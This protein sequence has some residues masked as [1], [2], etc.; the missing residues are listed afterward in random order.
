MR[1]FWRRDNGSGSG[2]GGG[3]CSRMVL[4]KY[5]RLDMGLELCR[6]SCMASCR[7][8][9]LD[10]GLNLGCLVEKCLAFVLLGV[11]VGFGFGFVLGF[12]LAFGAKARSG[13]SA[14]GGGSDSC[15]LPF[16][17]RLWVWVFQPSLEATLTLA[18]T[19]PPRVA[20]YEHLLE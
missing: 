19:G 5:R 15:P 18:G 2:R 4:C 12:G 3:R 13:T 1:R 8:V 11:K 10:L 9:C 14:A 20:G 16:V 7:C 6:L 17:D